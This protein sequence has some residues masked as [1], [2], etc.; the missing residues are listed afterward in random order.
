MNICS[1][2]LFIVQYQVIFHIPIKNIYIQLKYKCR[3]VMLGV[4]PNCEKTM[5]ASHF[6]GN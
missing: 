6:T 1:E 3:A 4:C 2:L 5:V